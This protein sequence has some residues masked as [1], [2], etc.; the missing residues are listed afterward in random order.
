MLQHRAIKTQ[1]GRGSIVAQ[2]LASALLEVNAA[3]YLPLRKDPRYLQNSGLSWR[4]ATTFS[5]IIKNVCVYN[6][7]YL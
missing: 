7:L 1:E 6:E 5:F 3:R 2:I 4:N